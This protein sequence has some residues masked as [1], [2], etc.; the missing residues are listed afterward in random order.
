MNIWISSARGGEPIIYPYIRPFGTRFDPS[1]IP[2]IKYKKSVEKEWLSGATR[3]PSLKMEEEEVT[4]QPD[5]I[6][7]AEERTSFT[8]S[9]L[10]TFLCLPIFQRKS[11]LEDVCQG[12]QKLG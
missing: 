4:S 3:I 9:H 6:S 5:T 2:Y 12:V 8:S 1:D 7:I 11:E 10:N